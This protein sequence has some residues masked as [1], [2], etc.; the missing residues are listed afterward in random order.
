[1]S[2][3]TAAPDVVPPATVP[4]P[5]P[6]EKGWP[7]VGVAWHMRRDPLSFMT[8]AVAHHGDAVTLKLG[9]YHA[10]LVRNPEHIRRVFVD[11]AAN[12]TKQTRGYQ[13]ARI[14]LGQ[15]LVTSEGEL[16]QR[17]R[18]I[19]TPAFH[20]QR[21]A[22]FGGGIVSLT[23]D[24]LRGW[25]ERGRQTPGEP[26]DV[27][28][29]MMRLT[30]RVRAPDAHG[31]RG[32]PRGG[33]AVAGR[34][35]GAGADERPH[36][37]PVLPP[38]VAAD[39]EEPPA[40]AGDRATRPVRLRDDRATPRGGGLRGA[41]GD[42][43]SMLLAARDEQTGQGMSDLQLRDEAVTILI[44]GHDTTANALT[45]ALHLLGDHPAAF[46]ALR[47]ELD[48]VLNGRPP[49]SA[50]LPALKYTR[51]VVEESMR[52]YP[53]AW[54]I[55]RAVARPTPSA[56]TSSPAAR[57]CSSALTS[58]TAT[59]ACGTT[60]TASTPPASSTAAPTPCPKFAY[61]PF[62]GGQRFCIGSNFAMMEATLILATVC[63][64]CRFAP[65]PA[66]GSS[67]TP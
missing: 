65:S 17:Q 64:S 61:L 58:P 34:R 25:R 35:R 6:V 33:R 36:Y 47:S 28:R 59:P 62:G 7:L 2:P 21:V 57:S 16:W 44:A 24:M 20:R 67:R 29:E 23:A 13:K 40:A 3:V 37:Q 8:R 26:L 54:M 41:P 14:V 10:T 30:L 27:F 56:R 38:R 19:A 39:A 18:R 1:M 5:A 31:R 48:T 52:L 63:Q 9:P 32:R 11:N 43:L 55:G 60:P 66:P 53:P 42:L 45:W 4:V 51:A 22:G 15:G 12:Y 49:T 46:D 50:D